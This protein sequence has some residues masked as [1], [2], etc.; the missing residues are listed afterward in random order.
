MKKNC[1]YASGGSLYPLLRKILLTMKLSVF[2][3]LLGIMSVQANEIFSQAKMNIQMENA[4]IEQVLERVQELSE[5]NIIYDYE[6]V[7][8]LDKIDVDFSDASLNDVLYGILKNTKLDYRLENDMIVLFPREIVKPAKEEEAETTQQENQQRRVKGCVKDADGNTLPGLTVVVKGTGKGWVTDHNGVFSLVL[9]DDENVLVFSF[10]GMKTVKV[11]LDKAQT[12]VDV[13]MEQDV[14]SLG[15]VVITGY[16]KIDKRK[17]TSSV[18]SID[19][20]SVVEPVGLSID[21]M[22]QGKVP[23]MSVMQA[24][25]T[26]GA[27]PK[28]RI[29]GSSS[30]LGNREPIWVVDGIILSDP[31]KI[32]N[33]DLNS[34]D[35]VNLIGNAI[36]FL[37]PQDIER[38]DVLKDAAATAIYGTKAANGVIVVTTKKGKAGKMLVNY[39]LS[40]SIKERPSYRKLN[41]MNSDERVQLSQEIEKRGLDFTSEG[42]PLIGYEGLLNDF[43]NKDISYDEFN[44]QVDLIRSANTDWFGEL[45]RTPISQTHNVSISGGDET[46]T[47]YVSG[48]IANDK[49]V[50]LNTNAKKHTLNAT[51]SSNITEK[52]KLNVGLNTS[53]G[54]TNR[55]HN[56]VDLM[57]YA[58]NTSRAIRLYNEDG[59]LF[60]YPGSVAITEGVPGESEYIYYNILNE[61]EHSGYVQE[62]NTLN[63]NI[64]LD[65]KLNDNFNISGQ[66][67]YNTSNIS[68]EEWADE[69]S[70]YITDK[71]QVPY[72]YAIPDGAKQNITNPFG[73]EYSMSSVKSKTITGKLGLNYSK[74]FDK[75]SIDV[76]LGSDI[77]SERYEGFSKM[78]FGYY[79]ERGKSFAVD[80]PLEYSAYHTFISGPD[81]APDLT[82]NLTNTLSFYGVLRYS[83]ANKYTV[84]FN[85]RTDGSNKFGQD[86]N[87][88]FLPVWSLSGRW[89]IAQ[90]NFVRDNLK[91]IDALAMKVSYGFQGN[92]HEDQTPNMILKQGQFDAR[93][94]QFVNTL[95]K[96][97]NNLLTWEKTKSYNIGTDFS[98]F[99][100]FVS[101]G[102]EYY[103]KRGEDQVVSKKVT[104][105]NG[106]DSFVINEGNIENEGWDLSLNF[107][108]VN[109][110]DI[111]WNL[112]LNTGRNKNKVT[113]SGNPELE[114][115]RKYLDGS[116]I[117]DGYSVNSFYSYRFNGLDQQGLP[118]FNGMEFLDDDY[119]GDINSR[120]A[121]IHSA[122]AY[123]G[124]R[125]PV[126]IGGFSTSVRYKRVMFSSSFSYALG[127]KI[128]L[129]N[130]YDNKNQTLPMPIQNM[131]DEFVKRWQ[132]PGDENYT[133]I[134]VVSD[135][136]LRADHEDNFRTVAKNYWQMY[137]QS[138]LRVVSGDYLRCS[139]LS[140]S[141][142]LAQGLVEKMRL[143]NCSVNFSCNNVFT[144]AS[145]KLRGQSPDAFGGTRTIPP[146]RTYSFTLNVSF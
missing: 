65:Y 146:Q 19:A 124:K 34:M 64:Q 54:K 88:R 48:S 139:S 1:V 22:L 93:A 132:N 130:L 84:N 134:P 60:Y 80:V 35:K 17:L 51:I 66:F 10:V 26:P 50:Q 101:G 141:Y 107:N 122:M 89:N 13:K 52:L 114:D 102:F 86:K 62:N 138:D 24:T 37:N 144:I 120:I 137:N 111:S 45:L 25:S 110:K 143:S 59:S 69:Q 58:Y 42:N 3:F 67:A 106:G 53:F 85:M 70:Y 43:W 99:N 61:L 123:S 2:L 38:I 98:L 126:T 77:R 47:Y 4:T 116:L 94:Q 73:G 6:Y 49:G 63:T 104:P 39:S 131:S 92:V 142:S 9:N 76:M 33:A 28:I 129:Y 5:Y 41:L 135:L 72:G 105:T 136:E 68:D 40:T 57:N 11:V 16:E 118:T 113:N 108:L 119:D 20:E 46:T 79:P 75:N 15:E 109:T 55:T 96:Y 117:R 100:G 44:R 82:D 8:D 95:V 12:W 81:Y 32:S 23:G 29:R 115:W 97:P 78:Q 71:R 145:S 91:F 27:A 128:R 7:K 74:S 36:S 21:K 83:F 125:E 127:N 14:E 87:T 133:N 90:E 112:S 121:A 30:I 140:L 103:L 31:V 18:F 56:S